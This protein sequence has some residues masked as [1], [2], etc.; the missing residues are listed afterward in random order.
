MGV[1]VMQDTK[2]E[3]IPYPY[4]KNVFG[5]QGWPTRWDKLLGPAH[6][7]YS[8]KA[9]SPR[10]LYIPSWLLLPGS[11]HVDFTSIET[12]LD[13][14]QSPRI[15]N[16]LVFQ[17]HFMKHVLVY[18]MPNQTAKTIA[19]F[20]YQG[21][22]YIFGTPA[23]PLSDRGANLISKMIEEMCKI[24]GVKKLQTTPYHPQTNGLVERSH[25]NNNVNDQEAGRRQKADWPSHLAENSACL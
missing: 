18:V 17:D 9:A 19:K 11:P 2:A 8:M 12:T 7:A 21:Y 14:N 6:S 1:I 24:L 4:Y 10:P 22:T 15:A 5:G 13:P 3:T 20:V 25:Q 23:R 16:I